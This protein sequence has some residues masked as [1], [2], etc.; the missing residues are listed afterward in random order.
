MRI[1]VLWKRRYMGQDVIMDRYARLYE[2]PLGLA[3]GGHEVLALCLNYHPGQAECRVDAVAPP[4][5]LVWRGYQAGPWLVG[6]LPGYWRSVLAELEAFQPAMLLGG[7]D[8]PHA[9]LTRQL[10][11]RLGIP[12]MLDLYDNY[13]AF[14]LGRLPGVTRLYRRALRG[15]AGIS[16]VSDLLTEYVRT[17]APGVP[18]MTLESTIDPR[19]FFPRDPVAARERLGLPAAGRLLGVS[20]SLHPNRGIGQVY[21]AFPR[22]SAADPGLHLVLA[23][24]AHRRQPPPRHPRI[25]WLGRLPHDEMPN[26]FSALDLALVPMIDT[27][28]GRYAF[29]QKAY[30]IMAC[31]TP[32]LTARVGALA[33]TLAG[34]PACLYDPGSPGDLDQRIQGQL[35]HPVRPSVPIPSWA[36]QSVRLA[37]F[38]AEQIP[39]GG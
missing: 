39:G 28:F 35:T 27:A 4:G 11:H 37:G 24:D 20:G 31:G 32:L 25:H 1:A 5:A 33:R 14:G 19:R 16:A 17:L 12:Y 26:Y 36:D 21:A 15:A 10:A 13:E 23:G 3:Q 38:I 9:I 34:Y 22:L 2:L 29:P 8:A 18:V 30:E 6:G 7:S